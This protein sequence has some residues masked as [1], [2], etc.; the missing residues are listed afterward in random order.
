MMLA[1]AMGVAGCAEHVPPQVVIYTSVDREIAQPIFDNF[2]KTTGIKVHPAYGTEPARSRSLAREI[3][4]HRAQSRCDIY[5]NKAIFDTLWLEREGLLRPVTPPAA[6]DFAAAS[7]S[8]RHTWY[9]ITTDARVLV[10]NTRQLAE[11][12]QPK[13]IEDLTDPQWYER[14]AIARPVQGASATH[15]A[16]IFQAWGDAKAKEFFLAVK[17]NARILETDRDVAHAVATGSLAFGLANASDAARELAA[18]G[19]IAIVYPD[20]ADDQLGTLFI[21]STLAVLKDSPDVEPANQLLDYLL[22]IG[23][24]PATDRKPERLG[25]IEHRRPRVGPCEVARRSP[26]DAGRH[27]RRRRELGHH[28]QIPAGRIHRPVTWQPFAFDAPRRWRRRPRRI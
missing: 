11:S 14:V 10:V 8:P 6:S 26:H 24:G 15:A 18:G 9:G 12:R 21:P 27:S 2:A 23:S 16:C 25:P 20:Q 22:S 3:V 1:V 5:W 28:G 7:H 19:P 4:A 17:R 13:S